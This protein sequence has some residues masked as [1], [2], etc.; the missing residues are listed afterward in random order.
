MMHEHPQARLVK[1][2]GLVL[3]RVAI[4]G[5]PNVGKS[6]LFNRLTGSRSI[7]HDRPGV[8][9]DRI[10]APC[11]WAGRQFLVVDTGGLVPGEA[12]EITKGVEQQVLRGVEQAALL[13]FVVDGRAGRTPLD[14]VLGSLLR[15]SGRTVLLV[16]NKVDAEGQEGRLAEFFP[17]GFRDPLPVSAEEGRGLDALLDRVLGF[18]P[19][20]EDGSADSPDR[21]RC[22]KLAVVGRPNVGKSTLFNRLAGEERAVVS[23]VP[24]TTRDPVKA[25][26]R[27]CGRTY[28][29][30]DTAGLR[31]KA[32]SE[33]E[34]VEVQSMARALAAAKE[35]D[36]VL[37][38]LDACE[39][40][41]HQDLAVIGTCIRIRRPLLVV[42]NK[43]D[44]LPDPVDL[45]RVIESMRGR[46]HFSSEVPVVPASA[47]K[48][49]GVDRV[50]N[51]LHS[52][53]H[54]CARKIP[55][56][57]LNAALEAAVRRRSPSARDRVPKFYYITQTGTF[58]PSFLIFTNG[59][60][61]DTPYRRYLT[62]EFRE[63]LGFKLAPV[64]LRFRKR[65]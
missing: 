48:G 5:A 52:L 9:R 64:S 51:L 11:E 26:F 29:V 25:E 30:V 42:L 24:G 14:E 21:P 44:R 65:S 47:R 6:R 50:L 2:E 62:R 37:A 56:P 28:Q 39:P 4:V 27:H 3:P 13:L 49:S 15:K 33:G 40:A 8:T 63:S 46:L 41:T 58:P 20:P 59:A 61:I 19:E 22:L 35:A 18:F 10:E 1:G 36:L 43:I 45:D 55:T 31:R 16:V 17:L 23:S 57:D 54:E 32:P 34:D 60:L 7:V 12:D 38:V 53:A